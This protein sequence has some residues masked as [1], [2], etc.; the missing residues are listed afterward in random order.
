MK[1]LVYTLL[2]LIG[3]TFGSYAQDNLVNIIKLPNFASTS[4]TFNVLTSDIILAL[5]E[6]GDTT[7]QVYFK[8]N[9]SKKLLQAY[10]AP[11]SVVGADS[12]L[13]YIQDSAKIIN[14][15]NILPYPMHLTDS[16]ST[17][18]YLDWRKEVFYTLPESADDFVTRINAL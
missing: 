11:N 6:A 13:V 5:P 14:S 4:D 15:A 3:L 12:R 2:I 8:D 17:L 7:T 9:N 18:K 1:R 16:T 10:I